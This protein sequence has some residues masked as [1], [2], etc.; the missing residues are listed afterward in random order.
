M[1]DA[2]TMSNQQS[3]KHWRLLR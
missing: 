1:L 3:K 2:Y